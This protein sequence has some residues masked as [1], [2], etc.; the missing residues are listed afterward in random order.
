MKSTPGDGSTFTLYLPVDYVEAA[1][2]AVLPLHDAEAQFVRPADL[3]QALRILAEQPDAAV[4]AGSTDF[5]VDLNLKGSTFGAQA[6]ARQMVAQREREPDDPYGGRIVF[7]FLEF[8]QDA[9]MAVFWQTL[10]TAKQRGEFPLN[11]FIERNAIQ[12]WADALALELVALH[13]GTEVVV[14]EGA[15]GQSL[16]VLRKP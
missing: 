14:P 3:P 8:A 12:R 9:H 4:V 2:A 13:D 10:A 5:G 11:V 6:A 1:Q 15:L 7:S 16:C